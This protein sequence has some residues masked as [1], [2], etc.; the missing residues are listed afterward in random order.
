MSKATKIAVEPTTPATISLAFTFERA[1]KNTYRFTEVVAEGADAVVGT[2]YVKQS[3][4][5]DGEPASL[6]VVIQTVAAK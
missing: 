1:T 3:A 4:F 5:P 2:L 6:A